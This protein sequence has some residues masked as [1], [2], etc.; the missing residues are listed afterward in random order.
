M[1][2]RKVSLIF[3]FFMAFLF[4]GVNIFHYS[5]S[6]SKEYGDVVSYADSNER[7][8]PQNTKKIPEREMK[9]FRTSEGED[10]LSWAQE[11]GLHSIKEFRR[12][13]GYGISFEDSD[14]QSYSVDTLKS[15]SDASDY[16]ATHILAR[17]MLESGDYPNALLYYEKAAV[18]DSTY[19]LK[20]IAGV[21]ES[22]YYRLSSSGN[23]DAK[24]AALTGVLAHYEVAIMRGDLSGEKSIKLFLEEN[25]I[26]LTDSMVKTISD[27]A[28]E[29][30]NNLS[31]QRKRLGMGEF[32]NNIPREMKEYFNEIN[33]ES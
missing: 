9:D 8:I 30:Y 25:D 24:K 2:V 17:K 3:T 1:S 13:Q 18:L 26:A 16:A 12:S 31:G 6:D 19:A 22:A 20:A 23:H 10:K 11:D 32:D 28:N 5:N 4:I 15:L 14:Y 29:I 27:T 21:Y 7:L 33:A